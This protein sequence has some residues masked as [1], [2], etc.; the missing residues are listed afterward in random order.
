ML[1]DKTVHVETQAEVSK[2]L[3]DHRRKFVPLCI[4]SA[5]KSHSENDFDAELSQIL[6]MCLSSVF[7]KHNHK[8]IP[9]YVL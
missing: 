4:M 7:R 3:D 6:K 8:G 5:T 2:R 9:T 1:P